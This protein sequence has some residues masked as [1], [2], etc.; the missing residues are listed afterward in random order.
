MSPLTQEQLALVRAYLNVP[1]TPAAASPE[2]PAAPAH[3]ASLP[4]DAE[5]AIAMDIG[6]VEADT[7]VRRLEFE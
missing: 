2:P 4:Y 1:R 3:P 7:A 5:A 6:D